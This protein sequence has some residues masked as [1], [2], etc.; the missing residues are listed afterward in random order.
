MCKPYGTL[1]PR[2]I[3]YLITFDGDKTIKIY[4]KPRIEVATFL[5]DNVK[6]VVPGCACNGKRDRHLSELRSL[7]KRVG[8]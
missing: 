4:G 1:D 2:V 8:H 6:R 7:G 3:V 5:L